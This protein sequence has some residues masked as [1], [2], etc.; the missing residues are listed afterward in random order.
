VSVG[1]GVQLPQTT[2]TAS[3]AGLLD[4]ARAA[5][6]AGLDSISVTERVIWPVAPVVTQDGSPGT[7]PWHQRSIFDPLETLS[8]VAAVTERI[9]LITAV[10]GTLFQPPAILARRAATVDQFSGG[11]L[12][13]G[14]G[15]AWMREE[16][17]AVH[18]PASRKGAGFEEN[19]AVLRALWGPDPVSFSGRFYAIPPS[20]Y[21]PKPVRP[22]GVPIY[23][24][25]GTRKG[26][27]RAIRFADGWLPVTGET[28]TWEGT[29]ALL[30]GF[31][32]A[33]D[34]AGRERLPI[35]LRAHAHVTEQ[36]LDGERIPVSGTLEQIAH[37][38]ERLERLGVNEI[39]LNQTQRGVPWSEQ[40]D[41]ATRL[42]EILS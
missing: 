16:F 14:V 3:A 34:D 40:L 19:I 29:E 42:K 27:E 35:R 33:A 1:V 13:F 36:P 15:Q 17:D 6:S 11:R 4:A 31:A 26:T 9:D 7:P 22:S 25:V 30:R 24:G 23:A 18:V 20:F 21:G 10:I 12:L 39:C 38:A 41:A 2:E 28:S 5:E 37:D 8:A 32:R